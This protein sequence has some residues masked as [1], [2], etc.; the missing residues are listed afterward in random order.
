MSIRTMTVAAAALL[1]G[2]AAGPAFACKGSEVLLQDDFGADTD[3]AWTSSTEGAFTPSDG[4]LNA[5][6]DPGKLA[7]FIYEGSFF[8][9]GEMCIDVVFPNVKDPA[10]IQAALEF[11]SDDAWYMASIKPDG[12]AGVVKYSGGWLKAVPWKKSDAIKTGAGVTNTIR[13]VWKGPPRSGTP[14]NPAVQFYI[15]DKLFATFRVKPNAQRKIGIYIESEGSTI[16]F[17]KFI[18]SR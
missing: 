14:A 6:S 5:K 7:E 8:P 2:L 11:L 18:A 16:E 4:K 17:R 3:P 10:T 1:V 12:N 13:V 9:E 15:N